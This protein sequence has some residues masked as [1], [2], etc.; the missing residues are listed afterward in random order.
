M[1]RR[2]FFTLVSGGA[3]L[4]TSR[5]FAEHHVLSADPLLSVFD[6]CSSPDR[7]TDIEDFY[8]RNHHATPPDTGKNLLRIEGERR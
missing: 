2:T 8:I 7:Y 3:L 6:L 1:D 4:A 5:L